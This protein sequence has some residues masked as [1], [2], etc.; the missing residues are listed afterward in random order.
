MNQKSQNKN[1]LLNLIDKARREKGLGVTALDKLA[2]IPN[3]KSSQLISGKKRKGSDIKTP[4]ESFSVTNMYKVLVALDLLKTD[5]EKSDVKEPFFSNKAIKKYEYL[6]NVN[7]TVRDGI[8]KGTPPEIL[9]KNIKMDMEK[10]IGTT[11]ALKQ[12]ESKS[13]ESKDKKR[14]VANGQGMSITPVCGA[15]KDRFEL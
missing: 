3:G 2:G 5:T 4:V 1:T 7:D 15:R 11:V 10:A 12:E 14:D 8:E 6:K 13:C 9:Y